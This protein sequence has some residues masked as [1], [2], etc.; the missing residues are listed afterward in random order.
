MDTFTFINANNNG[1]SQ[2]FYSGHETILQSGIH[3]G[4]PEPESPGRKKLGTC[5]VDGC[6]GKIFKVKTGHCFKHWFKLDPVSYKENIKVERQKAGA[7]DVQH[8]KDAF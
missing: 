3:R 1:I 7:S 5:K 6:D 2:S 4:Y 8:R